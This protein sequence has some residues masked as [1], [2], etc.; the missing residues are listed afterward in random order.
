MIARLE[1]ATTLTLR[2]G[3]GGTDACPR[4]RSRLPRR[5]AEHVGMPGWI[6]RLDTLAAGDP[7]PWRIGIPD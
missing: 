1:L 3:P 7:E 4:R 5:D 2:D 6:D